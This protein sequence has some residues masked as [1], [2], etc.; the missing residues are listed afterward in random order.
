MVQRI[1]YNTRQTAEKLGVSLYYFRNIMVHHYNI[2]H[3][4]A[5]SGRLQFLKTNVDR[6]A[7][8]MEKRR[9]VKPLKD[10]FK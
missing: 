9:Q 6:W 4:K 5:R 7:I 2:P 1:Y 8:E 3:L 10:I